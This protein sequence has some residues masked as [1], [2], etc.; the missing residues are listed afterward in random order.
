MEKRRTTYGELKM[1]KIELQSQMDK[2]RKGDSLITQETLN[3]FWRTSTNLRE[4]EKKLLRPITVSLFVAILLL[5]SSG[6]TSSATL[7]VSSSLYYPKKHES[8]ASRR[9]YTQPTV[10]MARNNLPMV[11]GAR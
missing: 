6:C 1:R 11:G 2:E 5:S 3:E 10:G 7:G 8:P 4:V 9:Q